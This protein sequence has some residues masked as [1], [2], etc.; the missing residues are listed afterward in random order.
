MSW[1]PQTMATQP[2]HAWMTTLRT[3]LRETLLGLL[4]DERAWNAASAFERDYVQQVGYRL[5][6]QGE[7]IPEMPAKPNWP[8]LHLGHGR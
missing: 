2:A 1:K 5:G 4:A 6:P 3:P 8:Y 7:W